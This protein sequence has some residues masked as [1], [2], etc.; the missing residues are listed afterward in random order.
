MALMASLALAVC[1]AAIF[2][3]V[4]SPSSTEDAEASRTDKAND[5]SR[6][7]AKPPKAG[8]PSATAGPTTAR[9][10]PT[11]LPVANGKYR[12]LLKDGKYPFCVTSALKHAYPVRAGDDGVQVCTG[13]PEGPIPV[14]GLKKYDPSEFQW[15]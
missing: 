2:F 13:T 15:K 11:S 4:R 5:G 10:D 12:L 14:E 3:V 1:L 9:T 8:T 6:S 7:S